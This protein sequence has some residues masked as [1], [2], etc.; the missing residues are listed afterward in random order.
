MAIF[1][2]WMWADSVRIHG[3]E[4]AVGY[5]VKAGVTD[6]Y[7]LTKGM[8]GKTAH[9]GTIAPHACER[10][11]LREVLEEAHKYSIRVHAWFTCSVDGVYY[12]NHPESGRCHLLRGKDSRVIS[13]ADE[14]Y[15]SYVEN[16][17]GEVMRHYDVDGFH[18][19]YI[20]YNHMLY[21]WSQEDMARYAAQGADV[22]KLRS[23]L[24]Y[25]NEHETREQNGLIDAYRAGDESVLAFART[26]RNDVVNMARRFIAA[27]RAE[28]PDT[29]I[30]AALLPEGAYEDV[31]FADLHYGQN[32]LDAAPL[33]DYVLP[34]SYSAAYKEGP[35]WVRKTAEV[36]MRRGLKTAVG[37]HAYEGGTGA[38]LLAD[39]KILADLPL[40]GIALFREGA[41]AMAFADDREL[42][43]YN[44]M[45][46][47]LSRI[48]AVA[49][50]DVVSFEKV[51]SSGEEAHLK[52]PFA[53]EYIR[54]FAGE[55]EKCV[56]LTRK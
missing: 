18:L 32:Y 29:A 44:A 34:M 19:D 53:P 42:M 4:K 2:I 7:F 30:T 52:L 45:D 55:V 41:T 5:C 49:G 1:G 46:D 48:E 50:G 11:L 23:M 10:D 6:I 16:M 35:E 40:H 47:S 24:F 38:S 51:L 26:R 25:M 14:G 12:E 43:V 13:L 31:S 28:K 36:S 22:E 8:G 33:Y 56:Y 20:R 21:G 17:I 37:L 39:E 27:A 9:H 15:L 3:A 54:V